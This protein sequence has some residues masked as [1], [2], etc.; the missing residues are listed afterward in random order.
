M[1]L[2]ADDG[3]GDG[4]TSDY[5][6]GEDLGDGGASTECTIDGQLQVQGKASAGARVGKAAGDSVEEDG[7]VR[8][9]VPQVTAVLP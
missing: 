1:A 8:C 2:A 9:S 6:G 4:H 3:D 5:K 7:E